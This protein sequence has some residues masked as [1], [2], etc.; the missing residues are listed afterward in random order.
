MGLSILWILLPLGIRKIFWKDLCFRG[1]LQKVKQPFY[2]LRMPPALG[3]RVLYKF[4]AYLA[5]TFP[6]WP[7]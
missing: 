5:D 3:L 1:R 6:G 4:L 2:Y 7:F